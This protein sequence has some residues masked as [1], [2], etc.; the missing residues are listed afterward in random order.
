M[1]RLPLQGKECEALQV[2]DLVLH[3]GRHLLQP[4]AQLHLLGHAVLLQGRDD[5]HQQHATA[6]YQVGTAGYQLGTAGYQVG[7]AG[8]QL[9]TA[10]YQLGTAGYQLG[11]LHLGT[12]SY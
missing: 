2:S 8:Y 5:L 7:T 12:I 4:V 10:G 1:S 3:S 9:G 11:T 6:G